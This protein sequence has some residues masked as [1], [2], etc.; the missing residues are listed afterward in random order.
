MFSQLGALA[1]KPKLKPSSSSVTANNNIKPQQQNQQQLPL[2]RERSAEKPEEKAEKEDD[3]GSDK[4]EN[5]ILQ[6][7]SPYQN[8][9]ANQTPAEEKLLVQ[10]LREKISQLEAELDA[11][12]LNNNDDNVK[13]KNNAVLLWINLELTRW[14]FELLA[15]KRQTDPL[16]IDGAEKCVEDLKK[17]VDNTLQEIQP[18][19][20]G[21]E[22]HLVPVELSDALFRAFKA[23]RVD[24]KFNEAE[25]IYFDYLLG[26]SNWHLGVF[27]MLHQRA[28]HDSFL[29]G[30]IKS[31]L[32]NHELRK[33]MV[34]FKEMLNREQ[35]RFQEEE[36]RK[37]KENL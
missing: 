35:N 17:F 4:E 36:R 21:L 25:T 12:N 2:R 29:R 9:Y 33:M 31:K 3:N 18:M 11:L 20:E 19:I 27:T 8:K 15:K 16:D 10:E 24:R 23:C 14:H 5:E 26:N 34:V 22:R 1:S 30:N 13:Q 6:S 32:H 28:A 37:R 7:S